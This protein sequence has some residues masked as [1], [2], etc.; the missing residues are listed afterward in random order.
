MPPDA[1]SFHIAQR[2]G[3]HQAGGTTVGAEHQINLARHGLDFA[4]LDEW[5][6][7]DAVTVPAKGNR[8]MAV[9]R[10]HVR[11]AVPV[12]TSIL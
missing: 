5:F 4:D 10:L 8:H 1:R 9:G 2:V 3:G 12:M 7:L 11:R 6:L